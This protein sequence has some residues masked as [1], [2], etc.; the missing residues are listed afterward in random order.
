MF[1]ESGAMQSETRRNMRGGSGSVKIL[2]VLPKES[3]PQKVRLAGIITLEKGCGIGKHE[4][5][6]ESEIFYVLSGEGVL[7]DNG[8]ERTIKAGDCNLC[9]SGESHAVSN[10][11]EEPL[12]LMAVIVLE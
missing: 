8:E 12:I 4:H 11:R 5:T 7:D 10:E 3:L 1:F 9:R 6:G 2:N